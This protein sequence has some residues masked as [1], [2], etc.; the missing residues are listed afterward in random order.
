M[1]INRS[2]AGFALA[3]GLFA[4]TGCADLE[5]EGG[6]LGGLAGPQTRG[7]SQTN[8]P[9]V[10]A[11]AAF[12]AAAAAT[13]QWFSVDEI[14]P[15]TRTVRS[16]VQEFDQK[17]GTGRIRD[18]ALQYRNRMRRSATVVVE[19]T[20][21]GCV[22]KCVVRVQRLDTAD[23]RVFRDQNR[24]DDYPTETPI[25]GEAGVSAEKEDVWTDMPRDRQLER[26]ILDAL[27]LRASGATTQSAG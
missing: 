3:A 15:E 14:S 27:K 1:R 24:F 7:W 20:G 17:G 2:P 26:E 13:R 5:P 16:R 21:A 19:D 6:P 25:D 8:L 11:D 22:A 12:E 4:V 23:H 18:A 9:G 10:S